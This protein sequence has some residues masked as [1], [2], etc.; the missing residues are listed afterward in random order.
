MRIGFS[1][2]GFI[3]A[4]IVDTPDG[5]RFWRRPIIDQLIALGHE[6]VMLQSNRDLIEA[7]EN[8]PYR[9][10]PGF[11]DIDALLC[12][13]RWPLPGRN[14]TPCGSAGHTCDL[15]RQEALLDH[16]T[17][18]RATP[19]VLWDTDRQMSGIDPLRQMPNVVVCDTARHP[20][21]GSTVLFSMVPDE[22][23][24]GADPEQLATADRPLALAYVGNQYDRDEAFEE[25]FAP[26]AVQFPHQVA[27]KWSRTERWPHVNF[28][29]RCAFPEVAGIYRNALATVMLLPDRYATVGALTQ[30]LGEAVVAGCLP[31]TPAT[32]VAADQA[33]PPVLHAADRHEVIERVEWLRGIAGTSE[34]V[35]LIDSCLRH[36]HPMRVSE[37]VGH[38]H[39]VMT[40]LVARTH[41]PAGEAR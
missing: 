12:E 11:P 8:L 29:G 27:G 35:E 37:Q 7:G 38:L 36:L 40:N 1:F 22:L 21:P 24:D 5:G 23:V 14:T 10:E 15:H 18:V 30:R 9:W 4:G 25:F 3:G 34:H 20:L 16:Y 33:I 19:T 31:I 6:I 13:W 32:I 2:W 41:S 17:Q 28:T 26:A 39:E